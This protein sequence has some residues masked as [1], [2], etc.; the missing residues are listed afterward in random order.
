MGA[1][2]TLQLCYSDNSEI[3]NGQYYENCKISKKSDLAKD[4]NFEER[5]IKYSWG[6]I[7]ENTKNK[8]KVNKFQVSN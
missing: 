1:Q 5:F 6:L 2:T 4:V 7:E 8:F 3:E